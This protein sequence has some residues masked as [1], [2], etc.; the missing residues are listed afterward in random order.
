MEM[1]GLVNAWQ[2]NGWRKKKRRRGGGGGR[3]GGMRR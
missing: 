1:N 3:G 2:M